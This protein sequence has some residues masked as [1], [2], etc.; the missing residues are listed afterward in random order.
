M[1]YHRENP[2]SETESPCLGL[3]FIKNDDDKLYDKL[4]DKHDEFT[5]HVGKFPFLS[6]NISS[7][8]SYGVY[9]SHIFFVLYIVMA[10][11]MHEINHT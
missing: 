5:F 9:I 7:S 10:G 3:L 11:V 6:G 8:S 2:K 4:Y 1:T